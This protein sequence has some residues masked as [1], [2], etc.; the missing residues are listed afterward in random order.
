VPSRSHST[1]AAELFEKLRRNVV[2]GPGELDPRVRRAAFAG[3]DVPASA[4][5]YVEKVRAH[6]YK[7][8]DEDVAA[9]RAAGWTEEAIF[10]LTIA[11]ALGA[12]L[13]RREKARA[14]MRAA[15]ATRTAEV[16]R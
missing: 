2:D 14:A 3:D 1:S 15:N 9:L 10:E 4:A 11:T 13:S 6:A 8:T 12:G 5:A 16:T 7:V